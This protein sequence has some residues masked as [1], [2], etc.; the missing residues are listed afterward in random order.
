MHEPVTI[1]TP[2]A[3]RTDVFDRYLAALKALDYDPALI[4]L[5][6]LDTSGKPDFERMLRQ[7]AATLP[8]GRVTYSKAPL[9][10]LWNQT[11]EK[12]IANRVS[13]K[14]NA[15]HFYQMAVIY[16]YN[17]MLAGCSTEFLFTL[18]DDIAPEPGA[19]KKLFEAFREDTVAAVASYPCRFRDCV[20][21]WSKQNG[22]RVQ[23]AKARSGV[24]PVCGSGFGCSLFRSSVL[25]KQPIHY[26]GDRPDGWYDDVAFAL[27]REHGSVLCDWD[28]KVEHMES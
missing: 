5:H 9:P 15:R 25:K 28:I 23:F 26:S 22:K 24:E 6:W 16:V 21:V 27:L 19:L 10:A 13:G 8:F 11:P 3:G 18:E 1:F 4:R 17:L 7:A 20:I 2:F 14:D 12:L